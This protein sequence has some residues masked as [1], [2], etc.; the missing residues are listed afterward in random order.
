L[1]GIGKPGITRR[2]HQE[3]IRVIIGFPIGI[4]GETFSLVGYSRWV[5][6]DGFPQTR[7]IYGDVREPKSKGVLSSLIGD[8][9]GILVV[10]NSYIGSPFLK[11]S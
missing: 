1:V 3:I 5:G 10:K 7:Y 4:R 2:V 6:Y 11:M 8:E 9:G